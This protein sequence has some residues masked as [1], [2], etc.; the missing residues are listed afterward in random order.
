MWSEMLVGAS[1]HFT[2]HS[3]LILRILDFS[4]FNVLYYEYEKEE[5]HSSFPTGP[6]SV[7][8]CFCRRV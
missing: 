2:I 5:T 4:S 7:L 1:S 8:P 3:N 6:A